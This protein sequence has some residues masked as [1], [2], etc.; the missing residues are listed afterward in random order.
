LSVTGAG[1]GCG[2]TYQWQSAPSAGGPWTNIAGA[3]NPTHA[4]NVSATTFFRRITYCGANSGTSTAVTASIGTANSCGFCKAF[5]PITIPYSAN[6]VSNCGQGNVLSSPPNP[7]GSSSYYNG[8]ENI[9]TFTPTT[10]GTININ[11]TS[12]G[13]YI[14]AML[15]DGCPNSATSTCVGSM[16]SSSGPWNFCVNV[17]AGKTYY[18]VVDSWPS[19]TCNTYSISITQSSGTPSCSLS[20]YTAASTTFN[21]Q[22][23]TGTSF[24]TTD[25]VLFSAI[26]FFGFQ[27]CYNGQSFQGAYIASNCSLVFD[28]YPCFPNIGL[29]PKVCASPGAYTGYSISI[30]APTNSDRTPMNAIL[31][32][33]HDIDPSVGGTIH[34]TT[35]GAAPNRTFIACW[36]DVPMFSSSCNSLL[37][38]SQVKLLENNMEIQIHVA[39]K[40]LC[41]TWNN[42]RAILGLHSFDGMTYIPPVNMTAHNSPTQWTMS[43]TAYKFTPTCPTISNCATPLPLEFKAFYGQQINNVNYVWWEVPDNTNIE[44]FYVERSYDEGNF[45]RIHTTPAENGKFKY[46]CRDYDFKRGGFSYYRVIAKLKSGGYSSTSIYPIYSTENIMLI[47]KFYPN[48]VVSSLNVEINAYQAHKA[49]FEFFDIQG[50]PVK[51]IEKNISFGFRTYSLD[52]SDLPS[53]LYTMKITTPDAVFMEKIL[54]D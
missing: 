50:R 14:G 5:I 42:G 17:T 40:P 44:E 36:H 24:P 27:F 37:H 26:T 22:N 29:P 16:Q 4:I 10:T 33:W 32:P 30:P 54:R 19:P 3:T 20:S 38:S 48:P 52:L 49:I 6:G 2:L 46:E 8:E 43:N 45:Q 13:S 21:F 35:L 41:S 23:F 9:Y 47:R 25:D 51:K 7:C 39:N 31:A 12:S 1:T 15:H 34:A 53:G 28:C 11:I 18:L